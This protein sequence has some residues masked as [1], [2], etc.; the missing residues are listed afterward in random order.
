MS[1]NATRQSIISARAQLTAILA[2]WSG[3]FNGQLDDAAAALD[4]AET[5]SGR[6]PADPAG[7]SEQEAL[8]KQR[9]VD[10]VTTVNNLTSDPQWM[11]LKT[12]LTAIQNG[13][14]ADPPPQGNA[15]PP[16]PPQ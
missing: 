13:Q 2:G 4:R 15:P 5:V 14:L 16:P 12:S 6:N 3:E 7:V 8:A 11:Q 1:Y 10:T 9:I